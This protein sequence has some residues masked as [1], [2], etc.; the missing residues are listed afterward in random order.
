M[1]L[2]KVEMGVIS[3]CVYVNSDEPSVSLKGHVA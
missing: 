1:A 2:I 3:T